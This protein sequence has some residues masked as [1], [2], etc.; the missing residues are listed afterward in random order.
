VIQPTLF[1]AEQPTE[2]ARVTGAT[3]GAILKFLRRRMANG[4]VEFHADDLRGAVACEVPI[5]PGSADRILRDLRRA[6]VV[7]YVVVN[8]AQSLYRVTAVR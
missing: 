1:D 8:R 4:F 5:A 7:S 3:A 6:G 2:L